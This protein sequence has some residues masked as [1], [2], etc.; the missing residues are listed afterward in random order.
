MKKDIVRGWEACIL[1]YCCK[2][3]TAHAH[4]LE[5]TTLKGKVLLYNFLRTAKNTS[6]G[7]FSSIYTSMEKDP[8]NTYILHRGRTYI[9]TTTVFILYTLVCPLL[10]LGLPC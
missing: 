5:I 10:K 9:L 8:Y 2:T 6:L 7:P 1:F 4:R 3:A